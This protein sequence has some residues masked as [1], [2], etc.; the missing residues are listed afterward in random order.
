MASGANA[1]SV[2]AAPSAPKSLDSE[3]GD[4]APVGTAA[5]AYRLMLPAYV[6]QDGQTAG[7]ALKVADC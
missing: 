4:V 6:D 3:L 2:G 7:F 5:T 1:G